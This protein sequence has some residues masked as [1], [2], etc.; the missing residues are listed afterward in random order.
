MEVLL[1]VC[2]FYGRTVSH[3]LKLQT[4]IPKCFLMNRNRFPQTRE[5][6]FL[7]FYSLRYKSGL[8]VLKTSTVH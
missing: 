5:H 7:C 1:H 2:V 6:S 3:T 8:K 4:Q